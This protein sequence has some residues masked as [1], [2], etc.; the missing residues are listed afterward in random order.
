MLKSVCT[1]WGA[2]LWRWQECETVCAPEPEGADET[3]A[4]LWA[5]PRSAL[6]DDNCWVY[7]SFFPFAWKLANVKRTWKIA[8]STAAI[9]SPDLQFGGRLHLANSP[10]EPRLSKDT[11]HWLCLP[12]KCLLTNLHLPWNANSR[13]WLPLRIKP[14]V[15]MWRYNKCFQGRL[16][17]QTL[18]ELSFTSK[19]RLLSSQ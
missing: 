16:D 17:T 5:T 2:R 6:P 7:S 10:W 4:T 14:L 3:P 15:C 12:H 13:V 11:F 18:L 1:F 8:N 19:T 9:S